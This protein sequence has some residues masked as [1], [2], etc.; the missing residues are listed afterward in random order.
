MSSRGEAERWERRRQWEVWLHR[1]LRFILCFMG[2]TGQPE[3]EAATRVA[4]PTSKPLFRK[5]RIW[6]RWSSKLNWHWNIRS[7][8]AGL[9]SPRPQRGVQLLHDTLCG[10]ESS[11]TGLARVRGH[12]PSWQPSWEHKAK[13]LRQEGRL[14]SKIHWW[15]AARQLR[16]CLWFKLVRRE[17]EYKDVLGSLVVEWDLFMCYIHSSQG[18]WGECSQGQPTA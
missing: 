18:L 5:A 3:T 6:H 8:E 7:S 10:N 13:L 12:G 1:W 14:E 9:K 4:P 11:D 16:N 17:A 2:P 15:K